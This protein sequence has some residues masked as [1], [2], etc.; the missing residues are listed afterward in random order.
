MFIYIK[1]K[2]LYPYEHFKDESSFKNIFG[3]LTQEDSKSPL[4]NELP[5]KFAVDEFKIYISKK[6]G[7]A[8]K[9]EYMEKMSEY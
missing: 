3:N 9:L 4:T 7:K 2:T 5:S 6:T 1:S 8:L